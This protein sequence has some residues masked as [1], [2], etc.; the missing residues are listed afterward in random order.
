M[1]AKQRLF[2]TKKGL[3]VSGNDSNAHM[4]L[5]AKGQLVPKEYHP[6]LESG[7]LST[8][9]KDAGEAQNKE[10]VGGSNKS[11]SGLSVNRKKG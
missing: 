3:V 1:I 6:Q 5:C 2:V 7:N 11:N 10:N 8:K 4:L 9:K